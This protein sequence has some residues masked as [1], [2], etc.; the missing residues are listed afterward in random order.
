[1]D[2][3]KWYRVIDPL[4][5]LFGCDVRVRN[6]RAV[7]TK[8]GAKLCW[9]IS[10]MRRI[11]VFVG[12][13]PFQLIAPEEES[14]GLWIDPAHLQDSPLQDD[15]VELGTDLPYGECLDEEQHTRADGLT[16]HAVTYEHAAQVA[17][18]KDG[19]L[20]KTRTTSGL[21]VPNTVLAMHEQ[22]RTEEDILEYMATGEDDGE[23][24]Q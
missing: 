17:L 24:D 12:D 16:V 3:V 1:M 18:L 14:L 7:V 5:P 10:A 23:E 20:L 11:D 15:V 22:G 6:D 9:E 8:S 4:N 2:D 19:K 21:S 13:R